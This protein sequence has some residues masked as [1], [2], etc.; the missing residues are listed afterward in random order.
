MAEVASRHEEECTPPEA[1]TRGEGGQSE[2]R[3]VRSGG[4]S[5]GLG[6]LRDRISR[7]FEISRWRASMHPCCVL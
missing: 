4:G 6:R 1:R 7:V 2:I 5:G 3:S